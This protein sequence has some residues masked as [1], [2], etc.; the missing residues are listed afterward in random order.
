VRLCVIIPVKNLSSSKA[1][2]AASLSL[3][4]R[5]D[6]TVK[7]LRHVLSILNKSIG[8]VLIIGSD[9]EVRAVSRE[10]N[11]LFEL[12]KA[13]SLNSAVVQ[14][15]GRCVRSGSDAVLLMA[16]DLPLLSY[17]ELENLLE[18]TEGEAVVICP[19]K[20]CGTN[21]LFLRPPRTM[22]VS[23]GANSFARHLRMALERGRRFKVFWSPGFSFDIDTPEDL[24]MLDGLRTGST[25]VKY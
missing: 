25:S 22:P 15:V 7:M 14:A 12:D 18:N 3:R 16:A 11:V 6:L 5:K 17:S 8:E 9:D 1:R 13:T 4:E 23:F 24:K 19:S 21:A 10:C 2:L 20:D